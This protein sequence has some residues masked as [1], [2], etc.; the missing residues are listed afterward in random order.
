MNAK[1]ALDKAHTKKRLGELIGNKDRTLAEANELIDLLVGYVVQQ[2]SSIIDMRDRMATQE[3]A[4]EV[5]AN[6][7]APEKGSKLI[8]FDEPKIVMPN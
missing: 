5:L 2:G 1:E 4:I 7:V 6:M 3:G 8:G